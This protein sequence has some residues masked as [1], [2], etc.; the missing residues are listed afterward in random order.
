[1]HGPGGGKV[2]GS[3]FRTKV[4]KERRPRIG[5]PKSAKLPGHLNHRLPEAKDAQLKI[6]CTPVQP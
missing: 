1:M 6:V 3:S 4:L 5:T 2:L